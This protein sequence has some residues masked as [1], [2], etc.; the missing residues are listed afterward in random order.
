[1]GVEEQIPNRCSVRWA[2]R[3]QFINVSQV[4]VK[5]TIP[6]CRAVSGYGRS[7]SITS[8]SRVGMEKQFQNVTQLG[9]HG[10]TNSEMFF[11]QVGM[12]KTVPNFI[13]LSSHKELMSISTSSFYTVQRSKEY[14][15]LSFFTIFLFSHKI[16][17]LFYL[18][19]IITVTFKINTF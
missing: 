3:K 14:F 2:R 12:E 15:C 18:D 19:F 1:M 13:Q 16:F 9:S 7:N 17:W 8:V 10:R 5:E 6:K 11:V 4:G